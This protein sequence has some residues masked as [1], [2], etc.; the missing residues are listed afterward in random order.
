MQNALI[1]ER[2]FFG[3][4]ELGIGKFVV[5]IVALDEERL[6]LALA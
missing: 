3:Q 5:A 6:P 1:G 2:P 4:N